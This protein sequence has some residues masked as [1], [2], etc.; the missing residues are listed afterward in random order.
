MLCY[1]LL[2]SLLVP[3]VEMARA[4]SVMGIMCMALLKVSSPTSQ[5]VD[6]GYPFLL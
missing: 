3:S 6:S 5:I 4:T 1:N 2:N